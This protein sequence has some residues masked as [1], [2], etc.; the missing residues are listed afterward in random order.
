MEDFDNIP[1]IIN[2][3]LVETGFTKRLVKANKREAITSIMLNNV[4]LSRKAE[5]D[6]FSQGLGPVL[7]EKHGLI[8]DFQAS[9]CSNLVPRVLSPILGANKKIHWG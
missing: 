6:Q 1:T 8:V 3:A 4:I 7:R 5:L 9:V 2:N